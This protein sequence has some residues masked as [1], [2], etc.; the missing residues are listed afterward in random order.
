MSNNNKPLCR[1]V[2]IHGFCKYEG[3]GCEFNH[4]PVKLLFFF[5]KCMSIRINKKNLEQD[6]SFQ[7][8]DKSRDVKI[9]HTKENTTLMFIYSKNKTRNTLVLQSVPADSINAPEFIPKFT[10]STTAG[11]LYMIVCAY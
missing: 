8:S 10:S 6:S 3:K 11:M 7:S 2:I 9:S 5:C 1:N 4:D